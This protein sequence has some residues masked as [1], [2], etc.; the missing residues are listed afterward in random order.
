MLTRSHILIHG[1]PSSVAEIWAAASPAAIESDTLNYH[2]FT[3][4]KSAFASLLFPGDDLS[5][6]DFDWAYIES[7]SM[8]AGSVEM[9]CYSWNGSLMGWLLRI[10]EKY[11]DSDPELNF[12]FTSEKGVKMKGYGEEIPPAPDMHYITASEEPTK[13]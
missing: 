12:D 6:F 3:S 5:S 11:K 2:R 13:I 8:L 7:C 1:T 10:R 9:V 4:E